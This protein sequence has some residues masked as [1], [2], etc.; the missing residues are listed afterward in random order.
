MLLSLDSFKIKVNIHPNKCRISMITKVA[1]KKTFL[2]IVLLASFSFT[3]A[4]LAADFKAIPTSGCS[5]LLVRFLDKSTGN[6]TSWKWDLGNGTIS[7]LRNP[8]VTYFNPGKYSIKLLVK[9]ANNEDS[10]VKVEYIEVLEKPIV[11]FGA[12]NTKGCYPLPVQFLDSTFSADSSISSWLWDF[13]DGITSSLKNP[14]HTY[15]T[16]GNFNVTLQIGNKSGCLSSITK[17]S[18]VQINTG[19]LAKFTN[20]TPS[21]CT[22]PVTINFQNQSTGTGTISYQWFFGDGTNATELNPSHTYSIPGSYTV[23]L[24]VSNGNGCTDSITKPNIISLGQVR[25]SFTAPDSACPNNGILFTNTSSPTPGS[26]SWAFGDS[27][28]SSQINAIKTF[29]AP[30]VYSVKMVANFGAC[31]DSAIK[32]IRILPKVIVKFIADDTTNCKA[33]F[34]VNFT[35]QSVNG[36]SYFWQFGDG[37]TSTLQTPNHTYNIEGNYTVKLKVTNVNGCIDSLIKTNYIVIKKPVIS[38]KNLPDSNCAP[39]TKSFSANINTVDPV[40]SYLWN[41]G[42]GNNSI[43]A[44]TI[45]T[46]SIAGI[47]P[48]SLIITT[49]GGCRDSAGITRGIIVN[50]RPKANF[51]A[52]PVNTCAKTPINFIDSTTP[53]A[54]AWLWN[55]GNGATSTIKNPIYQYSDTGYFD[56]TLIAWNRG[57]SDTVKFTKYI[58]ISPP[59]AKYLV[60]NNCANPYRKVFTDQSQGAD[61]WYWDFGD[62]STSTIKSPVHI[63]TSEGTF[64]T[65][66]RVVNSA[67]GCEYTAFKTIQVIDVSSQFIA[68]DT[69][70]CKGTAINFTTN[71]SLSDV[72]NFN[73]N[74]GDGGAP[75]NTTKNVLNFSYTKTGNYS[76]RLI[77]TDLLGCK[78]TLVKNNYIS[79]NGPTAKFGTS[80]SGICLKSVVTFNDSSISDGIHPIQSWV[81]NYGDSTVDSLTTA[82]FQHTYQTTGSY[83]VKLKITDNQ[84]CADSARLSGN[85]I[86]SQ[87]LAQFNTA[88]SL[89]CPGK[90]IHF[91]NQSTGLNLLYQWAFGDNAAVS[92]S[93]NPVHVYNADGN[94]SVKLKVTDQY[95]CADSISKTSFVKIATPVSLFFMSDSVSSCPPLIVN[96]TDSSSNVLSSIWDFGDNTSANNNNPVHFYSYPGTFNVKLTVTSPGG[97]TAVSQRQINISGPRGSFT[98]Q[99]INGCMPLKVNFTATV[100]DNP[101]IIWDF[102]DGAIE[103]SPDTTI[104]YIYTYPGSYIP[105]M[106]LV[107]PNGC[108]VPIAGKDTIIV[109][110]VTTNFSFLQKTICDA[111]NVSFKDSSVSNDAITGYQWNFGDGNTSSLKNPTH[112]YNGTGLKYPSLIVTTQQG[113]TDTLRS[114]LPIKIVA[115]PQIAIVASPNGCAPVNVTFNSRQV[116]PD[117]SSISWKWDFANGNISGAASPLAQNYSVAGVYSIQ[118]IATNS[119]GCTDTTVTNIEAYGIPTVDAGP[120]SVILCKGSSI[121]LNASGALDYSWLPATGLNCSNCA[122]PASSI[123]SDIK[124]VVTGTT[125]HGCSAKD[126][127]QVNVKNKFILTYSRPD[128]VCKGSTKKLTAAGANN[129]SW[130]PTINLDNPASSTPTV[131]PDTT[132]LYRVIAGDDVGCFKD[133][134]YVNIRVNPLPTVEAGLDK[135]INVGQVYDLV[136]TIS[137]DVIYVDWKPTTG[138]F[139]NIYPGITVKPTENTEYTVLVKNKGGCAA[140]DRVNVIVICNGGNVFIPN[141]FSPN[142]DGVNDVFYPRGT[143]LFKIKTLQIFSRWGELVFEKNS[144]NANDAGSGWNGTYKG[145]KVNP[146]VFVYTIEI[147]C[148]NNSILTYRGNVALVK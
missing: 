96:F 71:L 112:F 86:V 97:C 60:L 146:E 21:N 82:P 13:G 92:S 114:T 94:Y 67:S 64:N 134:G 137:P 56:I 24:I 140:R 117:T 108:Q 62:G 130:T 16:A 26:V 4:Q 38:F 69:T 143:G 91:N 25:A 132:T 80:L 138:L 73:W 113:C 33:P 126:S 6:P 10:V 75:V 31:K 47:Y 41:L 53:A 66:L 127:I 124:Y 123:L 88:D 136:P 52:T 85:I 104:S 29:T 102:N 59:V 54:S 55:F 131:Q 58:H 116:V 68:S 76:V 46:Y 8:S 93:Q 65:S 42:D 22:A 43:N 107:D 84:G 87:P 135:T 89:T 111:G 83:L 45:N 2:F 128:S 74:F 122:N 105:K 120:P 119:S 101:S 27:S 17:T 35:N 36:V 50:D 37:A 103:S 109:N 20:N 40:I 63:Y 99:P 39:F 49:A 95:G 98:Y 129:Y 12:G 70:I 5:P 100:F 61:K 77:I 30:G 72:S 44:T 18:F 11:Q 23:R 90:Q 78:D 9:T 79:V 3:Q 118:L 19:V 81:W 115:S 145:I 15:T 141:T 148:E 142:E 32:S 106:I 28:F 125:I 51:S 144:F 147:I 1:F 139:R 14:N 110:S 133:T 48:I 34:T 57:C 121:T 7:F